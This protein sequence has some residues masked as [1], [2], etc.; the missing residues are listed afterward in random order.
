MSTDLITKHLDIWA[1]AVNYNNGQTRKN[2]GDSELTG[3]DKLRELILELAV[4]GKLVPQDPDDEPASNLLEWIEEEKQRLYRDGKIKRPKRLPQIEENEKPFDLPSTWTWSRLGYLTNYG[5]SEKAE[6]GS[7]SSE[8]WV[9]ELED[10]EKG[11]SRIL[12][13][14]CVGERPFKSQKNI[15]HQ[16]DVVYGKLRPYLDKVLVAP[17]DGVCTT[18][19]VPF[20]GFGG[21]SSLYLR[22]ALKSP[23]FKDYAANAT[24]GMSLPRL[25]TANARGA[26]I[27]L[28]PV[29]EQ[30]QIVEK[31]D[32][33]MALCDR[34]EQ[35]T[36]DQIEA[37]ETLV[38]TL[39]EALTR[40][41]DA[42]ELAANWARIADNFDTLFTMEHSIDGLERTIYQLA[43]TGRLIA[44]DSN[45]EPASVLLTRALDKKETAHQQGRTG[46]R[47]ANAQNRG[48][49]TFHHLPAGWEASVI[50]NF[51]QVQGG[52]Q[53][54]SQR[55]PVNNAYPYLRVAEVQRGKLTLADNLPL[56]E[57]SD[58]ELEQYRLEKGDIL[59]VEGNGSADEI[60]RCAIWNEKIADCV[61]QN[62]LIRIRPFE[63]G[64]DRFVMLYLNSPA[65]VEEMKR[66]AVTT[67]GLYNL[68]VGKIRNITM[69]VP[70]LAEQ[71]RI[72][73]KVDEFVALCERLR[74]AVAGTC[75]CQRSLAAIVAKE[76]LS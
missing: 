58:S 52:I 20:R 51:A 11:S 28:P 36:R 46:E 64:I 74:S 40:S 17:D 42:D 35:Q 29:A 1:S 10:V 30:H 62:H 33:L 63:A 59:V 48:A 4:R 24:H 67:S 38:D 66:L 32:E 60:G 3:I 31:V 76:A 21:I 50:D 49:A 57:V 34:L 73:D 69:P 37:H 9:L 7:L 6:P 55:R 43:V 18:E 8:T 27:P 16:G 13:R 26:L 72:L 65:G 12:K 61:Y 19:M 15:F 23:F 47:H 71:Q 2:N 25:G 39:L 56:F 75:K 22:S 53:K 54:Q 70:P 5:D 44:Q 45:D 14:V 68:S 41:E